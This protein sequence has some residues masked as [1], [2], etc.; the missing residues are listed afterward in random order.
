M[1]LDSFLGEGAGRR[2]D[3]GQDTSSCPPVTSVTVKGLGSVVLLSR[4]IH[5]TELDIFIADYE[6]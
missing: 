1:I 4:N 5:Q 3:P 2:E 6:M